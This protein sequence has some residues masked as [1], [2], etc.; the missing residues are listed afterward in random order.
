MKRV[1]GHSTLAKMDN[2]AVIV[3]DKKLYER[4]KRNKAE[5]E[6]LNNLESRMERIEALLI[7]ITEKL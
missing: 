5:R 1:E 6:R 7:N 2:G 4:A 3:T